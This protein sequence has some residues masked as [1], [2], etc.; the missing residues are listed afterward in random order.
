[1]KFLIEKQYKMAGSLAR[2]SDNLVQFQPKENIKLQ[3]LHQISQELEQQSHLIHVIVGPVSGA[4]LALF[5]G[6]HIITS[7]MHFILISIVTFC[8]AYI[9]RIVYI[10][11]LTHR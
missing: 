9:L 8:L 4:I 2:D 7:M 6:Y 11:P 1:M 5:I 3:R 10:Y